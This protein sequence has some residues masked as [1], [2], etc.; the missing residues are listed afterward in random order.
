MTPELIIALVV[1]VGFG[2]YLV[3]VLLHPDRF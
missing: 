1:A 2:A 3:W